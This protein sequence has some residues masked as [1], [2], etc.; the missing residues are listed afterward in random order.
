MTDSTP[1]PVG[2]PCTYTEEIGEKICEL[3][4]NGMGLNAICRMD[5]MPPRR[6]VLD[7]LDGDDEA[8][9]NFR[10]SYTRA[11]IN[12]AHFFIDETLEIADDARN[13]WMEIERRKGFKEIVLDREH[14]ER[15]KLR[16]MTRQYTAEKLA[17]KKYGPKS[18]LELSGPDGGAIQTEELE[19]V[20]SRLLGRPIPQTPDVGTTGEAGSGEAEESGGAGV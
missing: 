7:W 8:L 4:A 15:S 1:R 18:A 13:D 14:V 20:K 12:Q 5:D 19:N 9:V 17:P 11:R 2:R 16:I 6:T 3:I 10:T